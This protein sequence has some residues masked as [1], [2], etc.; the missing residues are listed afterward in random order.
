MIDTSFFPERHI[1]CKL[2][3]T[4]HYKRQLFIKQES[5]NHYSKQPYFQSVCSENAKKC[6][7]TCCCFR[8]GLYQC[9]PVA[10]RILC[11]LIFLVFVYSGF[12][13]FQWMCPPIPPPLPPG[14]ALSPSCLQERQ[15]NQNLMFG[16]VTRVDKGNLA[17]VKRFEC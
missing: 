15:I 12:S 17:T 7:N 3:I 5:T 13:D 11:I 1:I 9:Y 8:C 10:S 2:T 14:K 4:T 16:F 6:L